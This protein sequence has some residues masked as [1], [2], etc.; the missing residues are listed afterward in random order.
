MI[1]ILKKSLAVAFFIAS[2]C[3]VSSQDKNAKISVLIVDGFSNHDWKQ[4]TK[5]VKHI[6]EKSKRF[7]VSTSTAPSSPE[8]K[9]WETWRPRFKDFDVV[10]QNTNNIHNPKIKW[11]KKV[12]KDLEKYLGNGGGLYILHSANNAF[13]DWEEYNLM[14]GLG[15]RTIDQGVG[16]KVEEGGQIS[17]IPIGKGK[18]TYHGP[19]QDE[20]ITIVNDH[21]INAGFPKEWKT[22]N[23]ELYKFARGPAKN[24]TVLSF[25]KEEETNINWPVEWIVSYGKGR[26]YN[27]SMGHLWAGETY[28]ISYQC[29]GF[30]TTLIRA[31][32]WLANG[33]CTYSIPENFPTET[34]IRLIEDDLD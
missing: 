14:I 30:Q 13:P 8:D 21:P 25:A 23:M 17:E 16:L 5:V 26:V 34:E 33:T 9:A 10:I 22:P 28:P 2:I 18:N 11:P 31:T 6:L 29:I 1:K 27:S 20:V 12:Q 19:R 7:E 3:H 4:T 32:E 24:L 15:W